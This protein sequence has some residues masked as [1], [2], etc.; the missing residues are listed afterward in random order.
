MEE[1]NAFGGEAVAN[2]D[3]V[4][5]LKAV[6]ISSEP[7]WMRP[8]KLTSQI[9]NAGILR[10]KSFVKMTPENWQAVL[11]APTGPIT[12]PARHSK[13]CGK[14]GF[15]RI[16]HDHLGSRVIRQL[17]VR[18]IIHP[19]KWAWVV[20]RIK[21]KAKYDIKVNTVAPIAASRLTERHYAARAFEKMKPEFVSPLVLLLCSKE[22]QENG[23]IY[24]AGMGFFNRV[25]VVT[26]PGTRSATVQENPPDIETVVDNQDAIS[27]LKTEKSILSRMNRWGCHECL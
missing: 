19:P 11:D 12:S 26:G 17:L 20:S 8:A 7:L 18:P 2:Y 24:N 13:S 3:N 6:K 16:A 23:N 27:S 22:C 5:T 1:I 25:A 21:L 4:A 15:G 14:N 10:D 9:N